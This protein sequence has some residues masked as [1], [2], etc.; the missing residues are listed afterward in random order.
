MALLLIYE[1]TVGET[2]VYK[3]A[4]YILGEKLAQNLQEINYISNS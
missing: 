3:R 1:T 2:I 4:I